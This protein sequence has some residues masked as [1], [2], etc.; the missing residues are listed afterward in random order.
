MSENISHCL[1]STTLLVW[2]V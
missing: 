1:C 2:R